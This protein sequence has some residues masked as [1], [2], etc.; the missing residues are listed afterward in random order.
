VGVAWDTPVYFVFQEGA[1]FVAGHLGIGVGLMM[2][3]ELGVGIGLSAALRAI[4]TGKIG[5]RLGLSAAAVRGRLG[6]K[7]GLSAALRALWPAALGMR[8]GLAGNPR[9][10]EVGLVGAKVGVVGRAVRRLSGAYGIKPGLSGRPVRLQSAAIGVKAGLSATLRARVAGTAGFKT[11]EVA[12]KIVGRLSGTVGVKV[13]LVGSPFAGIVTPCCP[14]AVPQT[15][16]VVS[17]ASTTTAVYS[18]GAGGWN[19]TDP[20]SGLAFILKCVGTQWRSTIGG[21]H[22]SFSFSVSGLVCDPFSVTTTTVVSGAL[23]VIAGTYTFT[24][25]A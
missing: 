8:V 15:L 12:S 5:I 24:I 18:S 11:G 3:P 19:F 16:T 4:L 21:A 17:G 14:N 7:A 25:H 6:V 23:C 1:G 10:F 13:G 9:A 20:V 22:C 2:N